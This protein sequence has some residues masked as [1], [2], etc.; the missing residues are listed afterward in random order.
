VGCGRAAPDRKTLSEAERDLYFPQA[1]KSLRVDPATARF[2]QYPLLA[3]IAEAAKSGG[4]ASVS[5]LY[6]VANMS[7]AAQSLLLSSPVVEGILVAH[8]RFHDVQ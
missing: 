7:D 8:V 2:S 1:D 3:A 6:T 5:N 4:L